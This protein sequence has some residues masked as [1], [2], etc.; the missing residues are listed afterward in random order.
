MGRVARG[1]KKGFAN[2]CAPALIGSG[3]LWAWVDALY[4]QTLFG[5]GAARGTV[6]ATSDWLASAPE[7][8]TWGIFL[9]VAVL[10]LLPLARPTL[11]RRMVSSRAALLATG[12]LGTIG[13]ACLALS[14]QLAMPALLA[15]GIVCCALYMGPSIVAWGGVYCSAGMHS[16]TTYVAGGF[17]CAFAFDGIFLVL[18]EPFSAFAPALLPLA[19]CLLLFATPAPLRAYAPIPA[20]TAPQAGSPSARPATQAPRPSSH[21][22]TR[23]G[24]L[25]RSSLG[26]SVPV[27]LSLAI[28]MVGLGYLQHHFSFALPVGNDAQGIPVALLLQITRGFTAVALYLC[29][30]GTRGG[31]P[32]VYRI[33]LLAIVAGFS[34]MPL[35]AGSEAFWVAGAVVLAGYTTF[36]VL[37]WVIVA[38]AANTGLGDPVRI[39]CLMRLFISSLFS[40]VGGMV[41]MT[42]SR[43]AGPLPFPY[44]D[45]IFVGYLMTV[46]VVLILSAR[47]VWDLF[48]ARPPLE[49]A[50]TQESSL[51]ERVEALSASWGLT[52]REREVFAYLAIG[53]TQ[54]WVAERLGIS[55]NTVNSH[56]RHLYAKSGVRSRQALLD[57]VIHAQSPECVDT[58]R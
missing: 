20:D 45:A 39:T 55:E 49:I 6:A 48:V 50:A 13:S 10:S 53:R 9:F 11:A 36:D 26:I 14:A 32:V 18:A 3:C 54:P 37:T 35:L 5:A 47:D 33:G 16:A 57:L 38:Q 31:A 30:L 43:G 7:L 42:V 40:G 8:A 58:P 28:V 25:L 24:S 46:A 52:Q 44:A 27:V 21:P 56:V 51:D 17:A 15:I 1:E 29:A 22:L 19:S 2:V 41:G 4:G 23:M 12:I 34:L